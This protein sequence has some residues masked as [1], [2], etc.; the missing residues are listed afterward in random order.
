MI[1]KNS[2]LW[3]A[4]TDIETWTEIDSIWDDSDATFLNYG[5][6]TMILKA[7]ETPY[8]YDGTTF[9]QITDW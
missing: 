7:D 2:K 4:D 5:K 1:A 3:K 6:Y 9:A 8:Y